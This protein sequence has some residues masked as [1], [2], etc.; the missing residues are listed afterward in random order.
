MSAEGNCRRQLQK[1]IVED[2]WLQKMVAGN[3]WRREL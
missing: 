1:T 3:G 2:G